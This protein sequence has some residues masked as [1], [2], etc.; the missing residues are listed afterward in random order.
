MTPT[1]WPSAL[2]RL[3]LS[4]YEK[5]LPTP[6]MHQSHLNEDVWLKVLRVSVGSCTL[7]F[8]AAS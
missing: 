2:E 1:S 7:L 6:D 4:I 3:T 8:G 5:S